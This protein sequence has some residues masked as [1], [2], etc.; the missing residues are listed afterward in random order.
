MGDSSAN[1]RENRV[2][3]RVF[4]KTPIPVEIGSIGSTVRYTLE[5]RDIS[6]RGFFLDFERPGRFPFNPASILEVWL[7]LTPDEVIFFN[8][9][10]ARVV[11]PADEKGHLTQPGIAITLVQMELDQKEKYMKYLAESPSRVPV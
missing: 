10:M 4:L 2:N 7:H 5:T 3:H 9:K 6:D 1:K 8:G 11:Y